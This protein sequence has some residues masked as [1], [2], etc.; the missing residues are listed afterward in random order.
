MKYTKEQIKRFYEDESPFEDGRETISANQKR[1]N[2]L[3][4]ISS[5]AKTNTSLQ[6]ELKVAEINLQG[7]PRIRI[8]D[9]EAVNEYEKYTREIF[10]VT[11]K[12]R[13][14]FW[15]AE[16]TILVVANFMIYISV[17][18]VTPTNPTN[19]ETLVPSSRP[20]LK[21]KVV[22]IFYYC[23]FY[24]QPNVTNF[25][26]STDYG[27][28]WPFYLLLLLITIEKLCEDWLKDKFG[29]NDEIIK[30][31]VEIEKQYAEMK[32]Q[33]QDKLNE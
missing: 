14:S 17:F 4:E 32:Q 5:N 19:L 24:N 7:P 29:T 6:K 26:E 3:L 18:I 12:V 2:R 1:L 27:I 13:S 9:E 20:I 8:T 28:Y 11:N 10:E 23:G 16:Y 25:E 15:I 22:F 30:M 21:D 31:F 33:I